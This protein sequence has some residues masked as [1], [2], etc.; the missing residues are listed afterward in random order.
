MTEAVTALFF[1]IS[2]FLTTRSTLI[3]R[4]DGT[5]CFT[6]YRSQHRLADGLGM[7]ADEGARAGLE[8]SVLPLGIG[9]LQRRMAALCC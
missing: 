3:V 7:D 5:L 6:E 8:L 4:A 1:S 2:I 9:R